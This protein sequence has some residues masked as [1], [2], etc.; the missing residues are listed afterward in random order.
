MSHIM[1]INTII[2]LL[3]CSFF[4]KAITITGTVTDEKKLP[5]PLATIFV[6]GTTIGTTANTDGVY[7]IEIPSLKT[8]EL[9]VQCI[10][11]KAMTGKPWYY[12]QILSLERLK[13]LPKELTRK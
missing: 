7:F 12:T 1:K 13:E 8:V 6:K 2:L 9:V 3:F 5:I 4:A 11:Y 10:G